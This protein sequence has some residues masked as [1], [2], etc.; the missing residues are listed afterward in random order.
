MVCLYSGILIFREHG[1]D[2][3]RLLGYGGIAYSVGAIL[4]FIESP[5]I[6]PGVFETHEIF[7]FAIIIGIVCHWR[8]IEQAIQLSAVVDAEATESE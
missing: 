1:L 2:F 7:H 3:V 5:T 4:D 8:F 6:I